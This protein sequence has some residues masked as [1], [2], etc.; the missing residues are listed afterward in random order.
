[1]DSA[2]EQSEGKYLMTVQPIVVRRSFFYRLVWVALIPSLIYF[3][4]VIFDLLRYP[5]E[6]GGVPGGG[7]WFRIVQG[8]ILGPATMLVGALIVRRTSG[9]IV[10]LLLILYGIGVTSTSVRF[11]VAS[12]GVAVGFAITNFYANAVQ[13]PALICLLFYFPNGQPYPRR[14]ENWISAFVI[15][16]FFGLLV[17]VLGSTWMTLFNGLPDAPNPFFV[18]ALAPLRSSLEMIIQF[19][20]GGFLGLPGVLCVVSIVL[21]YRAADALE[22]SQIRWLALFGALFLVSILGWFVAYALNFFDAWRL[23]FDV[24]SNLLP[25]LGVGIAILRY[26]LYDIDI[27]IRRTLVYSI[28]T[29]ILGAIYF[30]GVVLIQHV[31]QAATGQTSDA[32]IVISTLLIAALFTPIRRRVQNTIDRRFYRRKYDAEK[33]LAKFNQ[34]LRDEVD[35]EALKDSLLNV[36]Q[37]TMQPTRVSLWVKDAT[38]DSP[39]GK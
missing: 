13:L 33:T 38:G 25:T 7:L 10:G 37:E 23:I 27:I 35:I 21:R 15:I 2:P 16:Q 9:N 12:P 39:K 30:G 29:A 4:V 22:R 24:Y 20:A 17:A 1:V 32:A 34:S 3:G 6:L 14:A 31:V 28:L 5:L 18:P 36:V 19:D 8:L 11:D 26:R